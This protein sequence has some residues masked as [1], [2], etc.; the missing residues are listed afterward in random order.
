MTPFEID[1]L[2][3]YHAR[4]EDHPVVMKDPP[5]WQATRDWFMAEGLLAFG[6]PPGSGLKITPR[7]D[8]YCRSLCMVPPPVP[9]WRTEWPKEKS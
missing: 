7:G 6:P 8:A 3:W 1:I 4:A 5:I 9:S 2:M